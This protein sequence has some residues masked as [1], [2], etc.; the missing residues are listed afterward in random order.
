[1]PAGAAL[2]LQVT[3]NPACGLVRFVLAGAAG[4]AQS[5][6]GAR[7]VRPRRLGLCTLPPGA[8]EAVW[9]GERDRADRAGS[10]VYF[11]RLRDARGC[12]VRWIAWLALAPTTPPRGRPGFARQARPEA[13]TPAGRTLPSHSRHR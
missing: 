4:A 2:S 7:P 10:G 9:S 8:R 1:M 5:S 6:P 13:S 11:A 3:P 12:V